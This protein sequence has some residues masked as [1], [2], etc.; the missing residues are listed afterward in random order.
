MGQQQAE[1]EPLALCC[2]SRKH[3]DEIAYEIR[4]GD[5]PSRSWEGEA[6]RC[7]LE[8]FIVNDALLR[9]AA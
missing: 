2:E 1:G 8:V 4:R 9:P 6:G 5:C 7:L 3:V